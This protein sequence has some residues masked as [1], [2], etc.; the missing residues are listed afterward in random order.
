MYNLDSCKD[1]A[2]WCRYVWKYDCDTKA[3]IACPKTCNQCTGK[4]SYKTYLIIMT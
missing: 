3:K 1:T 2:S 4:H